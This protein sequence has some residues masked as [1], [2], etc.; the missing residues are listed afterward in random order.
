MIPKRSDKPLEEKVYDNN[1]I[2]ILLSYEGIKVEISCKFDPQ[3]AFEN[4]EVQKDMF[5]F[6]LDK[7]VNMILKSDDLEKVIESV[8]NKRR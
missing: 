5:R 8:T 4:K 3:L 1:Y 7:S 6:L 2:T